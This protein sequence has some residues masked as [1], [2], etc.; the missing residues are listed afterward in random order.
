[1]ERLK[2]LKG[3]ASPCQD[4][5]CRTEHA[6]IHVTSTRTTLRQEQRKEEYAKY[7]AK[8][9]PPVKVIAGKTTA[10]YRQQKG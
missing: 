10:E 4:C 9:N 2:T 5:T 1:M 6:M 3:T 8:V 7:L